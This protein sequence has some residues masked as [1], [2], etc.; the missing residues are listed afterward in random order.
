VPFKEA[1]FVLLHWLMSPPGK[2]IRATA[3]LLLER[4]HGP[5]DLSSSVATIQVG[6]SDDII[7]SPLELTAEV[8][9]EAACPDDAEVELATWSYP[10]EKLMKKYR[11]GPCFADSLFDGGLHIKNLTLGAGYKRLRRILGMKRL[12][13]V[14]CFTSRLAST[15]SGSGV[16]GFY[17]GRYQMAT[18]TKAGW[19]SLEMELSSGS[20][21]EKVCLRTECLTSRR[22]LVQTNCLLERRF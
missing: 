9:A 20:F 15:S 21:L 1:M 17:F 22:T 14:V 18:T 7:F 5:V 4:L 8:R 19:K 6:K 11:R 16:A 3:F 2:L 12:S 10:A 13:P